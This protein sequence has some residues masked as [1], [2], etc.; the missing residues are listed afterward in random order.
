MD[1]SPPL[2][3]AF[4]PADEATLI[5]VA[6]ALG[7]A[8]TADL[9]APELALV[10]SGTL[11]PA[12]LVDETRD[13][14]RDGKDPLGSAFCAIR[15]AKVRRKSGAVYTPP[16][17]VRSIIDWSE[18]HG[19]PVRVVE[20]G[21]GSARFLLE[22]A[23]RFPNAQI[24]A[25]ENDPLAALLAR[26]N[27]A[28]AGLSQ[29]SK[30]LLQD[31]RSVKL[32]PVDGQTLFVG[33]PPYVRHHLIGPEW[34]AWLKTTAAE[35]GIKVSAL[36]GLHVYFFLVIARW[37]NGGDYGAFVTAGEW[38]DVNYGQMVRDLFLGRLGG[39]SVT[40]IEPTAEP[41]PGVASTGAITTFKVDSKPRS[42]TFSRVAK[43]D[44]LDALQGG[45]QVPRDRLKAESRWSSF[46]RATAQHPDG[47][48]ELGELCAVHRGQVTGANRIW[49]AG[50]H[51]AGLPKETVYTTVT[52]AKE[53]LSSE[54]ELQDANKLRGV[55]DL[56]EDLS[57][58]EGAELRAIRRFLEWAEQMG[59]PDGY[60]ARHRKA[61]WSVGL[62]DPAPILATYMAR[63]APAFVVNEAN[64]RHLNIA[65]GLYP[66]E[67]LSDEVLTLLTRYLRNSVSPSGGR[68][69]SGG[70]IKFEPREMER[71]PVP[72]PGLLKQ[73][74]S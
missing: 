20:P 52:R 12:R 1:N 28:V 41:F 11:A 61:W 37:G 40:V 64:V 31:F 6:L 74:R 71:I 46:T 9:S 54:L 29:R 15:A 72:E 65:H 27:L 8:S 4:P 3:F 34:K 43:L 53:L 32:D 18:A 17:I 36:A 16:K 23:K 62:R 55:I 39:E 30:V 49:I 57:S 21:A 2:E 26:A 67:T 63:R 56:P 47:F 44:D 13:Q 68:V 51:S 42:A 25:I 45:V 38:L 58:F 70:L 66:R 60:V 24:V 48:V 33:N 14:I 19:S 35:M 73:I 50:A 5:A 69:Y 59:A 10:P 7:A 22:A